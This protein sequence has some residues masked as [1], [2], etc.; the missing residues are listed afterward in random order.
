MKIVP[1]I[2]CAILLT[3]ALR[4]PLAAQ[5]T[6]DIENRNP[7]TAA[8]GARPP[9]PAAPAPGDEAAAAGA[10]TQRF[11]D[12]YVRN[13]KK[14]G[15]DKAR[16][17]WLLTRSDVTPLFKR[18]FKQV[19]DQAA[20]S[21]M[22]GMEADPILNAQDYP[23]NSTMTVK[24]AQAAGNLATVTMNWRTGMDAPVQVK[25]VKYP[26]GWKINGIAGIVA[27]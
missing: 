21:E 1:G 12:D 16:V 5:S 3:P 19:H 10:V 4:L 26:E 20:K 13:L 14:L 2:L 6:K 23:D 24:G 25:L 7:A 18:L 9:G 15:R 22:G 17:A 11:Y 8:D 27:K